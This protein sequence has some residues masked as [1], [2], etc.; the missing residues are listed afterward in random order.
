[1]LVDFWS[2]GCSSCIERM[3]AIKL[4][5]DKYKSKGFE[6]VSG[7]LNSEDEEEVVRKIKKRIE[8][9]WPILMLG[10]KDKRE[11]A[12]SMGNKIMRKYGFFGVPQ[13]L[14]LNKQGKL[15]LLNDV[16]RDGN[17]EP[18]VKELLAENI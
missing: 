7:C 13:L 8:S 2:T 17:F 16:L 10:G 6:V 3:P 1:V 15:V 4:V 18:I 9:E 12:T 11:W 14:L 5:Y